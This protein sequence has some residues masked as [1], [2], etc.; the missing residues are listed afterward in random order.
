M[1]LAA[2]QKRRMRLAHK[3][4]SAVSFEICVPHDRGYHL[5][6]VVRACSKWA[7]KTYSFDLVPNAHHPSL[8]M[9]DL[10][11]LDRREWI[12]FDP[13]SAES[14]IYGQPT[15]CPDPN[16]WTIGLRHDGLIAVEEYL[17]SWWKK[18]YEKQPVTAWQILVTIVISIGTFIGGYI[19]GKH[20]WSSSESV[21]Q[22]RMAAPAT[23]L[24]AENGTS[25]ILAN[26]TL[27]NQ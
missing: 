14:D 1:N 23:Q 16:K 10:R 26:L 24:E 21:I 25:L 9:S 20:D 7:R 22:L 11:E 5:L 2:I 17:K 6:E 15:Y 27:D 3:I 19:L 8:L 12:F 18:A 4:A 13:D